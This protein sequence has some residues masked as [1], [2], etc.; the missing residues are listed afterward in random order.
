MGRPKGSN[1]KLKSLN[2][3]KETEDAIFRFECEGFIGIVIVTI[4]IKT[5]I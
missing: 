3:D 1:S 2:L 4:M 5:V